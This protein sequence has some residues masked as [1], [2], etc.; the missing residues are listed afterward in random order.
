VESY[1]TRFGL[2][3]GNEFLP[4]PPKGPFKLRILIPVRHFFCSLDFYA[5][6][7]R[8]DKKLPRVTDVKSA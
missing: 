1:F 3:H 7:H 8:E 6:L 5:F 4:Q 2:G